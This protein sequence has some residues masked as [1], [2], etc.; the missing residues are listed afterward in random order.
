MLDD[1]LVKVIK[2]ELA[3]KMGFDVANV[4]SESTRQLVEEAKGRIIANR[5]AEINQMHQKDQQRRNS[6][7]RDSAHAK[8]VEIAGKE[9]RKIEKRLWIVSWSIVTAFFVI[10]AIGCVLGFNNAVYGIPSIAFAVV[11]LASIYDMR[12]GRKEI[13][14]RQIEKYANKRERKIYDREYQKYMDIIGTA[15]NVAD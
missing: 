6:Q 2:R 5:E 9:K 12:R 10:A 11:S 3:L 8:A 15:E 1:S 13:I 4:N 14:K 7:L